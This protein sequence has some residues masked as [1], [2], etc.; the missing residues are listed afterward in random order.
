MTFK[1]SSIYIVLDEITAIKMFY[2]QTYIKLEKDTFTL[3]FG[4]K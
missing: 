4:P 2:I 1:I 3:K